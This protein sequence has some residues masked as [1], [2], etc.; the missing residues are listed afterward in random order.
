MNDE[1]HEACVSKIIRLSGVRLKIEKKCVHQ[2]CLGEI[3]N[4]T[5]RR[6]SDVDEW[7]GI[8]KA[9]DALKTSS[10]PFLLAR[11]RLVANGEEPSIIVGGG[12]AAI[13]V[14]CELT[15]RDRLTE[16]F[17]QWWI[18]VRH[19]AVDEWLGNHQPLKVSGYGFPWECSYCSHSRPKEGWAKR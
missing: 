2:D 4:R 5:R 7:M 12:L 15:S 1:Q 11:G 17:G 18:A 3:V 6:A 13:E 14:V 9:A 8:S 10:V 19:E 16:R